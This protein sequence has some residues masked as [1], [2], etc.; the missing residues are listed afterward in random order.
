MSSEE[1]EAGKQTKKKTFFEGLTAPC[2]AFDLCRLT[3]V[4]IKSCQKVIGHVSICLRDNW[5]AQLVKRLTLDLSSG[6]DL[7]VVTLSPAL[8]SM[9]GMEPT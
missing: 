2:Q 7:R 8:G 3:R 6:L 9:L 4:S 1:W 5:V